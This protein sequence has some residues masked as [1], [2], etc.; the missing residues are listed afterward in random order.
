MKRKAGSGQVAD[1]SIEQY[2]SP[3]QVD[4]V[5]QYRSCSLAPFWTRKQLHFLLRHGDNIAAVAQ[6]PKLAATQIA[7]AVWCIGADKVV[8]WGHPKQGGDSFEVKDQLKNVQQ[9]FSTYRA[10]AA[11]FGRWKRGDLGRTRL[12]L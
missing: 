7:F 3:Y 9:I 12:C 4:G 5:N 11:I 10:F 8:T 1:S 2:R 6:Q